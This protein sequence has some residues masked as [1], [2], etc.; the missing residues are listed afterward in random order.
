MSNYHIILKRSFIVVLLIA[1][2]ISG[3]IAGDVF[4]RIQADDYQKA[5]LRLR[6]EMEIIAE[7]EGVMLTRCDAS[8][9]DLLN[10][11][12]ISFEQ[13]QSYNQLSGEDLPPKP[14][15]GI[16][17][18]VVVK[19][20]NQGSTN[21]WSF[22]P[23]VALTENVIG[24]V[25]T[26]VNGQLPGFTFKDLNSDS[27]WNHYIDTDLAGD[28]PLYIASGDKNIYYA[29]HYDSPEISNTN[30]RY[31]CYD[32]ESDIETEIENFGYG[33]EGFGVSD[34]WVTRVGSKG[35]G[36]NNQIFAHNVETGA[37]FEMLADSLPELGQYD[38]F[39]AP[40][41]DGNTMVFTY[42]H[43]SPWTT[44]LRVYSLGEDGE[45]GTADDTVSVL[46]IDGD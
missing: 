5:T 24:Y 44:D 14:S 12:G 19:P 35:N 10:D 1:F 32:T 29:F 7:E 16:P 17:L 33:Y 42:T 43:A 40:V 39:G 22:H 45:Q 26:N 8:A 15:G 38:Y 37:R 2:S 18:G 20:G 46:G 31:Y 11:E 13:I 6:N 27:T 3:L 9:A 30:M 25:E 34:T 36:W 23:A 4:L 41:T 21:L 28:I